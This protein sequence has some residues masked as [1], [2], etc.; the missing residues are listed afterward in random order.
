MKQL[1]HRFWK[2]NEGTSSIE[3]VLIFP[4]FFGFFL[5]AY[6]SGIL[7]SRQ[8]MLEHGLDVTVRAVRI[9]VID[10]T[11]EDELRTAIKESICENAGI[12]PDCVTQLEVE[13]IQR[14][15]RVVWN[16]LPTKIQCV[17]RGNISAPSTSTVIDAG[18]NELM[19]LRACIR[20]DPFIPTSNL[21]KALVA[22]NN[23]AAGESYALVATSAFVVEPFRAEDD[24][25]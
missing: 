7:S 25:T 15:P 6:E 13:M 22:G 2:D 3:F 5:T 19:F 12:L 1:L 23:E 20:I 10:Q 9:G 14:D 18:N 4:V 16:P 17:D 11:D 21:G 24:G 8:V